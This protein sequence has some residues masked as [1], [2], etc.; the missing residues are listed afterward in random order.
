MQC[1]HMLCAV[2]RSRAKH[3]TQAPSNTTACTTPLCTQPS[4]P[5]LTSTSMLTLARAQCRRWHLGEGS[6]ACALGLL[7][8]FVLLS[9]QHFLYT[10]QQ[11]VITRLLAFSA[12]SFFTWVGL[13]V[14]QGC[15]I[16]V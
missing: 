6:A 7:C 16:S 8:G 3:A 15:C 2:Q 12:A 14:V 4:A 10:R 1:G 11:A 5:Y 9:A 13:A